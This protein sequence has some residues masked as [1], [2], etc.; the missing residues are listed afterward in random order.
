MLSKE[1]EISMAVAVSN[2]QIGVSFLRSIN[3]DGFGGGF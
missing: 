3:S 2:T 1:G